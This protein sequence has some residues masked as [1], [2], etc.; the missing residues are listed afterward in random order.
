MPLPTS[1]PARV[2][3]SLLLLSLAACGGSR[4]SA[5]PGAEPSGALRP[6]L[7]DRTER[8]SGAG[9]CYGP[10]RD[11]QRPGGPTPSAAE[12]REDLRLMR[13][14]WRLLRTYGASEFGREL[15]EGIRTEGFDIKVLLGVWV[16]PEER[17]GAAGGIERDAEAAAANEREFVAAVALAAAYPDIVAAI[18]VGNETQVSWSP[19]PCP[20]ELLIAQVRRVRAAVAVPVTAADDYQYWLEPAS[21]ALA[22]ELD[23]LT[24]HAHPMWNGQTLD[25]ALPWLRTQLAAVAAAHPSRPLVVGETGWATAVAASGEQAR[26]IKGRP[27]EAE[28]ASFYAAACAWAE[29]ERVALFTFE[30]FD[31]NWKGGTDPAEVEKHW[32]LFRADRTPKAAL[33][34]GG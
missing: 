6:F 31:E 33:R 18:C 12:I 23:F 13:P 9:I 17:P 14:H 19:H 30:A 21:R 7:P 22:R 2:G 3:L 8:W 27:G 34:S 24:V 32:G 11:G 20:I 10:H 28:Q 15:L 29:R 16:A 25:A 1:I 26:L 4:R 5:P